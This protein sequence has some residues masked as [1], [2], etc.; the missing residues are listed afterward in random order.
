MGYVCEGVTRAYQYKN[1]LRRFDL[2]SEY[3]TCHHEQQKNQARSHKH[4]VEATMTTYMEIN[5]NNSI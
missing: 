3:P 1:R 2:S 4:D 5:R